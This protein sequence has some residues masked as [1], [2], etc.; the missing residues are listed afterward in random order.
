MGARPVFNF[1]VLLAP[2]SSETPVGADPRRDGAPGALYFALKDARATARAQE[3][4]ADADEEVGTSFVHWQTVYELSTKLLSEQAKDLEVAA[5]LIEASLRL[6]GF[7]G[8][9][10]GFDLA[11]GLV[12]RYW[13]TL[14]PAPDEDGIAARVAALGG[15]NGSGAEGT[16]IQ[17]IR[18]VPLTETVGSGPFAF[19]HYTIANRP[20]VTG[21]NRRPPPV[22][23]TFDQ[24]Q[25][26]VRQSSPDFLR[27]VGEDLAAARA[28]FR[29]LT[30]ELNGRC[31]LDAPSSSAISGVLEEVADAFAH[32]T[33][34]IDLVPAPIAAE[35]PEPAVEETVNGTAPV[36][37]GAGPIGSREEAFR[38]L[39]EVADYF[40]R[41]EPHSPLSYT[42]EDLVRRGRMSLPEL[43]AELLPDQNAR[44]VFLTAAGI[45][46][47]LDG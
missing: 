17:A 11:R 7:A 27:Q 8:L 9:R 4:Q 39:L 34:E 44:S 6:H 41:T 5:W 16:L 10:D 13:D 32:L 33:S 23:V 29:A 43:L 1:D 38:Q 31:G 36:V 40:R 18:K 2:I 25:D 22:R 46:P 45:R 26:A 24:V 19:W 37:A 42:L 14:F 47:K 12:E 20:P 35:E 28:A 3:R 21:T 30:A 15:L